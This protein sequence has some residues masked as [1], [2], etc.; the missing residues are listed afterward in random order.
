[1]TMSFSGEL[2]FTEDLPYARHLCSLI[3]LILT[4]IFSGLGLG[5]GEETEAR[6][7]GE[8]HSSVSGHYGWHS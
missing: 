7:G 3:Y 2:T 6:R 5:T 1:M 4:K 8:G